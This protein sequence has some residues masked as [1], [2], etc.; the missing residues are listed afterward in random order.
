[1]IPW[2]YNQSV[3]RLVTLAMFNDTSQVDIVRLGGIVSRSL[4][5]E[6]E[7][8]KGGCRI[9]SRRIGLCWSGI[10]IGNAFWLARRTCP[11]SLGELFGTLDTLHMMKVHRDVAARILTTHHLTTHLC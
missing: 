7:A 1:L 10:G 9:R 11:F 8:L 3:R 6:R 4:G 5:I 2:S